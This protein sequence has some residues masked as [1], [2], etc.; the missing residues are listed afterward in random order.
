MKLNYKKIGQGAPLVILH[1]LFG[2]ADNW[3]GIAK[4]LEDDYS[5]YLLDQRNH[6]ESDHHE[7]WDYDVMADDLLEFL[8][9]QKLEKIHLMGHSM[10]GK[11][12][13]KFALNHPDRVD[14]LVV[15]DIAPRYYPVHHQSIL[16][17]LN[18]IDLEQ[19][20]SRRSADEILAEY[21]P[22]K[23]TRQFLL[24]SLGR[25]DEGKFFWKINLPVITEKIENASM[26][27]DHPG[28]FDGPTLFMAGENSNYIKDRD[29]ED[30]EKYF[31]K[32]QIIRMKNAGHWIHAEQPEAVVRTV[33]YFLG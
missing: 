4:D 14:K 3:L 13:M 11:T 29:K 16:D 33:Q 5:I 32:S 19:L 31:P 12:A 26:A 8:E 27:I 28:S 30:I 17:G 21:E 1:G 25:N 6:G 9:E 7:E 18:A 20:D 24:K 2:S 22:G 23:G 10:G 15:V